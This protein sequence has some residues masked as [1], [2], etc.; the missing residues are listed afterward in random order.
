MPLEVR[1]CTSI[2]ELEPEAWNSLLTRDDSPFQQWG[3]LASLERT[4]CTSARA[5]WQ[6][7]HLLCYESNSLVGALP[8]F[9][10]DNSYGEFI[11]DWAWADAAARCG[12]NYYPKLVSM[13]PFTPVSGRSALIAEGLATEHI[14]LALVEA[15]RSLVDAHE[16]SSLHLLYQSESE[17]EITQQGGRLWHRTTH[18]YQWQ[19]EGYANFGE[20]LG[21]F[22][23]KRRAQIRRERRD[24]AAA[25][26][27]TRLIPGD[28]LT[29]AESDALW[30]FYRSTVDQFSFQPRYLNRAFFTEV[31]AELGPI[32]QLLFAYKDGEPIAGT[33][34][35]VANDVFYGRYWGAIQHIPFLHFEVC[36]YRPIELA[37]E[38]GWTRVEAGA[39]GQHKWGRGF[40]PHLIHSAHKIV[41]PGL[42]EAVGRYLEDERLHLATALDD[43][44]RWVFKA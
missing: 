18:Q 8:L 39:G 17:S 23:S 7:C 19:N 28:Q 6:A 34:N 20:F 32:V 24:V 42:D 11:F 38:N 31:C 25:G 36:C 16:C 33:F 5:G 35:L 40:L 26:V 10:K 15:A 30:R 4:G 37:I 21:R 9:L 13:I 41:H 29:E 44:A 22:R 43:S 14:Y 3:F 27:T 2:L 1:V 12:I